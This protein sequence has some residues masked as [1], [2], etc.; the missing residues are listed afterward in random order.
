MVAHGGATVF[1]REEKGG[2][3]QVQVYPAS[4]A[5]LLLARFLHTPERLVRNGV[6]SLWSMHDMLLI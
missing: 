6:R 5:F 4:R 1:E 3:M 2:S